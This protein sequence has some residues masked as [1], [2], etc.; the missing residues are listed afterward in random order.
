VPRSRRPLLA[1]L[2]TAVAVLVATW[3][4]GPAGLTASAGSATARAAAAPSVPPQQAY[5]VDGP[6]FAKAREVAQ[7]HWGAVPCQGG[8]VTFVWSPLEPLTNARA[9]WSN[10]TDA[11]AD[12][13]TNYECRVDFN[14]GTQFDFPTLCTVMTHEL[15]HLLGHQHDAAAGQLMSP[16][17]TTPLPECVAADPTPP[18]APIIEAADDTA[19]TPAPRRA[20]RSTAKPAAKRKT[21]S[22]RT[23][24][25]RKRCFVRMQAGRR[26]RRCVVRQPVRRAAKPRAGAAARRS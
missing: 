4:A 18:P 3:G 17:Y 14:T 2:V 12:P 15:G 25:R 11:W 26:V 1:L 5:P 10:P 22:A 19:S 6:L 24:K 20:A 16:I 21:T 9:T 7:A 13:A 23:A 8:Q